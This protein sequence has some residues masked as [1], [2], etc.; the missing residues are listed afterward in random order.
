MKYFAD[1]LAAFAREESGSVAVIFGLVLVVLLASAGI[2]LDFA[3][4]AHTRTKMQN[5]LDSAVLAGARADTGSQVAAAEKMFNANFS[6]KT[7]KNVSTSFGPSGEGEFSGSAT[8]QL[9]TTLAGVLG[10]SQLKVNVMSKAKGTG[11]GVVCILVL[12]KTASQAFLVNSG[13]E[14]DAP[15]CELHVKSTASPAA[16]FN[17]GSDLET[18]R[19]CIAGKS[20]IDNG[21]R[22]PNL[23]TECITAEDPFAGKLYEPSSASCTFSNLNFNGGNVTLKPGVYCGWVNFNS[24]PNVKF[25]PGTYILKNGG[26][27]VNGGTWS[28]TG[29]TFYFADQ[30]KIQFN[31]AVAATISAPT[32][33]SYKDIVMFEKSG[34]SRSPLVFDDSRDM[35]LR[36]IMYLPSRDVTFNSGSRLTNKTMTIVVNTLILNGTRWDLSPATDDILASGGIK[37]VH[38]TK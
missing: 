1:R 25:E 20:I 18:K 37:S 27:N 17:A 21:G 11:G 7:T 34:L 38:L 19:I 32:S 14:V 12:D 31:S 33:G 2:A 35:N 28:G 24:S 23:E 3:R 15:E 29:V 30:S 4:A 6:D 22:H 26:W 9:D 16:I 5:A 13:P 10:I 8:G 36:G